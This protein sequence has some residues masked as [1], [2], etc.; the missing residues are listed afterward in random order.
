MDRFIPLYR[1]YVRFCQWL[2]PICKIYYLEN[3]FIYI[4]YLPVIRLG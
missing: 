3:V 4:M 1:Y 2:F